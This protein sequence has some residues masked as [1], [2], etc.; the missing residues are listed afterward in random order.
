MDLRNNEITLGE[1]MQNKDASKL[2]QSEFGNMM[3]GPLY[4]MAKKMSLKKILAHADGKIAKEK[5]DELLLKL[6]EI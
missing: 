1:I 5:I 4:A 6:K 2:I 3:K